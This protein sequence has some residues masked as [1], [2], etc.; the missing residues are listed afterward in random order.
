LVKEE[1]GLKRG[2]SDSTSVGAQR[3]PLGPTRTVTVASTVRESVSNTRIPSVRP[4][5]PS[6]GNKRTSRSSV[7]ETIVYQDPVEEDH[8]VQMDV[9]DAE[10]EDHRYG[11]DDVDLAAA[12]EEVAAMVEADSDSEP[13]IEATPDVKAVRVWPEVSTERAQRY[14]REIQ[15]IRRRFEDEVDMYDTTMVSEY[16]EEIFEYMEEMEV[17]YHSLG[18]GVARY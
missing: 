1:V 12:E 11:D 15:E 13:E 18:L 3:V 6:G 10:L 14:Q 4:R 5:I 2:R 7:T 8:H 9:E 16:A 17:C